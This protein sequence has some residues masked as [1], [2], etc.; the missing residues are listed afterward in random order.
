MWYTHNKNTIMNFKSSYQTEGS[1]D[2]FSS[3]IFLFFLRSIQLHWNNRRRWHNSSSDESLY[4]NE[5]C[6]P[7]RIDDKKKKSIFSQSSAYTHKK[8]AVG[9]NYGWAANTKVPFHIYFLITANIGHSMRNPWG[10]ISNSFVP[11][12]HLIFE[13]ALSI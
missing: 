13:M 8:I 10:S 5:L 11:V 12:I 6:I 7:I 2:Q 3:L 4:T 9:I 1:S